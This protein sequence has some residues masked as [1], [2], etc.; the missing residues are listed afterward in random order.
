MIYKRYTEQILL[1]KNDSNYMYCCNSPALHIFTST[2]FVE[3]AFILN[4][5][6]VFEVMIFVLDILVVGV[7]TVKIIVVD[8]VEIILV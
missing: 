6:D 2:K 8:V 3:F 1:N 4:T 7:H 5:V